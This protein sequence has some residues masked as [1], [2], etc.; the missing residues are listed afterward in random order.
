MLSTDVSDVEVQAAKF[1]KSFRRFIPDAFAH[2]EP[3]VTYQDNWHVHAVA[4]HL[5]AVTEG[6]IKLL[7]INVPP[8]TMKSLL[9]CV[10]WP[11]WMWAERDW[12]RFMFT[13]Y[14]EQFTKRDSRKM[15]N[16][17]NS[18]WY[19]ARFPHV[20]IA[21]P[22]RGHDGEL[23]VADSVL[24]WGTIG[25]GLRVGGATSSGVTGKHVHGICEDD[26]MKQQD[27]HSKAKREAAWQFHKG[28]LSSRL[29]PGDLTFRL[30]TMQRLHVD[31]PTGRIIKEGGWE[32]LKLPMHYNPKRVVMTPLGNPDKRTKEGELLWP[33]RM[34]E[35]YVIA[36]GKNLGPHDAAAQEEQEPTSLEGGIIKRAWIKRWNKHTLP[37]EFDIEWLS[38]DLAL[39]DTGDPIAVQLWGFKD[40]NFYLRK[41]MTDCIAFTDSYG[42]VNEM[43]K[44]AGVGGYQ[45]AK[46]IE[47]KANGH[48]MMDLNKKL[49]SNIPGFVPFNPGNRDKI[50]RLNACSPTWAS[51]NVFV[52]DEDEDPTIEDYIEQLCGFPNVQHDDEVDATSQ[53]FLWFAENHDLF[54]N[55]RF[56]ELGAKSPDHVDPSMVML[57]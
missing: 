18:Q 30:V 27:A 1:K 49:S 7:V 43:A 13:S 25:G 42:V 55:I 56:G 5:Q 47:N 51:G 36:R 29:L 48:A 44:G 26:P 46:V 54:T 4:E 10:L 6:Q 17:V 14:S 45:M 41:R 16:L 3:G 19:R 2:A 52:P 8:G 40:G 57:R 33:S 21:R 12:M 9:C 50:V 20:R 11:A 24:E 35:E 22:T 53:S 37:K 31:D 32:L 28:A 34:T 38:A 15:R 39:T 23:Q